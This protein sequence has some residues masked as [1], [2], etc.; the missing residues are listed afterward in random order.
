MEPRRESPGNTDLAATERNKNAAMRV[1]AKARGLV[2]S[3]RAH[4]LKL[5]VRPVQRCG[6]GVSHVGRRRT[7]R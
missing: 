4:E 1:G 3:G 7:S 5:E 6:R 2:M